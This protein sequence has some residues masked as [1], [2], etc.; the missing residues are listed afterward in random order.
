LAENL[1]L[2]RV[3]V[4]HI[5]KAVKEYEAVAEAETCELALDIVVS[6]DLGVVEK[7]ENGLE[8]RILG[9]GGANVADE[10]RLGSG[11]GRTYGGKLEL[12]RLEEHVGRCVGCLTPLR[13]V[14]SPRHG[15]GLAH[16][17]TGAVDDREVVVGEELCPPGLPSVEYFGRGEVFK[18]LVV[19]VH[20]E[21][22]RGTF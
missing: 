12:V 14:V 21:G 9:L 2:D 10:L 8:S 4:R 20:R 7:R 5:H 3:A 15:I 6:G 16:G 1:E 13:E 22:M 11:S 18:V 19:R 17:A